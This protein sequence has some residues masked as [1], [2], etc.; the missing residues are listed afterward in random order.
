MRAVIYARFSSAGQREE[1]IEGQVRECR[2]F[3]LAKGMVVLDEYIDRAYTGTNDNRPSF[4]KMIRDSATHTF[5]VVLC[6][7]HDRFARNR[8]DAALYKAKLKANGVSL[9]YAKEDVPEGS[10]GIIIESI[11]EGFAEYYSA[12]LSENVNR[13]LYESALKR[14]VAGVKVF[15]LGED[16]NHHYCHNQDSPVVRRIFEEYVSGKPATEIA[17]DLNREGFRTNLGNEFRKGSIT[18]IIRNPKYYGLY[19]YKG[20]EDECIPPI[21]SKEMWNKANEMCEDHRQAPSRRADKDGY[22]LSGKLFCGKC[23]ESMTA[24]GGTGRDG[25]RYDYYTCNG[26]RVLHKCDM[27]SVPKKETEDIIVKALYDVIFDDEF[28]DSVA[29]YF[30]KWQTEDDDAHTLQG[31]RDRVKDIEKRIGNLTASLEIYEAP[32][33]VKRIQELEQERKDVQNGIDQF[34]KFNPTFTKE[35]IV[36]FLKSF[37]EGD[38]N[39]PRWRNYLVK[40]FLNRAYIYE[41]WHIILHLNVSGEEKKIDVRG[42]DIGSNSEGSAPPNRSNLNIIFKYGEVFVVIN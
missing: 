10:Q 30:V 22:I 33:V 35:Q 3:A 29:D 42:L 19:K 16:E 25:K 5:D 9:M 27:K 26:R 20:I 32:S 21:V 1:S 12:N 4:Q 31:L 41:D 38:I 17:K 15:G 37:R 34:T 24:G 2:A 14:Q 18:Q 8:Y 40:S 11:M 39:D 7:K 28:I 23:G 36:W 6:W 13:G